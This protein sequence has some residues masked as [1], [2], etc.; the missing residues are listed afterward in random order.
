MT[1]TDPE[2]CRRLGEKA[3]RP[4]DL[5][6]L[7][8]QEAIAGFIRNFCHRDT[9]AG[10]VRDKTVRD[11]GPFFTT[12]DGLSWK[13][14]DLSTHAPVVIWYSPE[15]AEWVRGHRGIAEEE[16]DTPSPPVPEGAM[17]V[18]EM[19]PAPALRCAGIDPLHLMPLGGTALMIRDSSAAQDGWYWGWFGWDG[20]TPDYPAD[21]AT[22][23]PQNM[24]FGPYCLNCHAS[25]RDNM[26]FAAGRNMLGEKG[27]LQSYLIQYVEASQPHAPAVRHSLPALPREREQR[28]G[29]P[30]TAYSGAFLDAFPH[31]LLGGAAPGWDDVPRLPSSS[32]DNVWMPAGPP[33][34]HG[35][36]LTSTQCLGCHSGGAT[37][38]QYAMTRPSGEG[39]RFI[40]ISPYGTW[41]SSPMGLAGRDPIFFAQLASETQSFHPQEAALVEDTCLGCHGVMGQRQHAIDRV[42]RGE[43]C[44]T[45]GRD[46]VDAAPWPADN[47]LAAMA[48]YGALARDGISCAACH[49]M[50]LGAA[51][52]AQADEPRN[53][54]VQERQAR[55]NP[56]MTGFAATFTGSFLLG[57]ADRLAGPYEAPKTW[58]M[59][60][61]LG[62]TPVHD[63]N[64]R[65]SEVCG[66]CHTIHLPVLHEGKTLARV[67]EQ[68]TYAEWAFSDYRTGT[69]PDGPL[70]E[71]AGPRA[72]S[73]QG[74]HMPDTDGSG[75][76]L[77]TKIAS[78]QEYSSYPATAFIAPPE[79]IDLPVRDRF[80][81]HSLVGLNLF[82]TTFAQ[83]FPE[84]LGLRTFDTTVGDHAIDPLLVTEKA[85]LQQAAG[86]TA[87]VT[88]APPTV[89]DGRL[90]AEV[91]VRNLAGHRL[92]SGVGFR[93]A[94]LSFEVLDQHGAPIWASG[95]T[96]AAGRLVDAADRPLDGEVWWTGDC[97]ARIRPEARLHQPHFQTIRRQDQAQ[98]YQELSAAPPGTDGPKS[99]APQCGE[100]AAPAGPLTTSFLSLC[101]AVKDNRLPPH[102][103]LPNE[104]RAVIAAALGAGPDLAAALDPVGVG[105]DPDYRDG[106]GRDR[107]VYEVPLA[108]LNAVP[109]S[110]RARLYYQATP[111]H[112][113]QDRFCTAT[114]ADR[115]RLYFLAGHANLDG[116]AIEG[117]KLAIGDSGRIAVP[118]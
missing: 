21:Q 65:E 22:N 40:D 82:L 19:Y 45:F 87:T 118:R 39:S 94:F 104:R 9:E 102:G 50:A 100:G 98:V 8:A 32:Y 57:P 66:S 49:R 15:A 99:A 95:R 76:K 5:P 24:G 42:L 12:L 36:F 44:G 43:D 58:P 6:P 34:G 101:T 29:M 114:G 108:D 117:W 115:D 38:R 61:A 35:Q 48:D 105:N 80:A 51:A 92:P 68:T 53:A 75:R 10:W 88:V 31:S 13:S 46:L 27:R 89:R 91:E 14:H 97:S 54:C 47:P 67:Y 69:S 107:I 86:A 90:R 103:L 1:P 56:G 55:L 7:E 79:E 63:P 60:K 78:I 3:R 33:D 41:V 110:V 111:P 77:R 18:K 74:C 112:Y 64:I 52:E 96:D 106:K 17:L 83:Q 16:A 62:I 37:W 113:L 81:K 109:A 116:T 20:W 28:L 30:K 4:G 23:P 85:I 84:I 72:Q 70:P 71:G 2:L 59:R 93:R 26:T 25:A 11:T 73:C